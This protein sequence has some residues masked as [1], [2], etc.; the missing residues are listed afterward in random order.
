MARGARQSVPLPL[1]V[2]SH[3]GVADA[4]WR[5]GAPDWMWTHFPSGEQRTARTGGRLRKMGLKKGW[6]DFVLIDPHG[7]HHWMELKRGRS[8]LTVEQDNFKVECIARGIP[9]AVARSLDEAL[10][11]LA[12]WGAIR[13]IANNDNTSPLVARLEEAARVPA[14]KATR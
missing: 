2:Q 3:I 8:P 13:R 10:Q 4:L 1:E 11:V 7:R 14:R 12:A 5:L 9:H 6:P